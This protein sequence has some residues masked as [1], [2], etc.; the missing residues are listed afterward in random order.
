MKIEKEVIFNVNKAKV[1]ELLTNP[2]ITKQYMF[3]CEV[4][5][6]WEVGNTILWKGYTEEGKEVIYVKG[7]IIECK[8]GDK[9]TFTMFDPNMEIEDIP[10]NYLNLTYELIEIN[11]KTLLRLT[12]GNFA[13]VTQGKKRYEESLKGWE[14]VIPIMKQIVEH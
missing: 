1:W 12:Q 10:E 5:S 8:K 9:V 7:E 3:G 6:N 2:S 14:M 4:L 13:T 11:N